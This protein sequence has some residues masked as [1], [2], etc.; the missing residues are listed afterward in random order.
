MWW[1]IWCNEKMSELWIFNENQHYCIISYLTNPIT[2]AACK[3]GWGAKIH[4]QCEKKKKNMF[5]QFSFNSSCILQTGIHLHTKFNS[6]IA[7]FKV[8][9]RLPPTIVLWLSHWQLII[10]I[11]SAWSQCSFFNVTDCQIIKC[12]KGHISRDAVMGGGGSTPVTKWVSNI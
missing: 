5:V 2:K 11:Q 8:Y 1:H 9:K 4:W 6:S 7:Q 10:Y 12:W 3:G